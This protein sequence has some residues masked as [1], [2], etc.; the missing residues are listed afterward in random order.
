[1]GGRQQQQAVA[2]ST[3]KRRELMGIGGNLIDEHMCVGHAWK[4]WEF[5]RGGT[6]QYNNTHC[7]IR[8]ESRGPVIR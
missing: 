2:Y 5:Q 7:H 6:K 4:M 1:M 8:T 3:Q